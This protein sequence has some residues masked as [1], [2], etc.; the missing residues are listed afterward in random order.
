MPATANP[1]LFPGMAQVTATT[2]WD[3]LNGLAMLIGCAVTIEFA[4]RVEWR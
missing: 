2:H 4:W 1:R 3:G